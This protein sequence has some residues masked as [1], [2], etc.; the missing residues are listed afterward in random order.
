MKARWLTCSLVCA[1]VLGSLRASERQLVLEAM[2]QRPDDFWPRG[3]GHVVLAVPGSREEEK[4]YHE[5]GGSF[6]PAFA[7]FGISL[8]VLDAQGRMVATS[9]SLA[10]EQ[11]AQRLVWPREHEPPGVQ[12]ETPYYLATW[13]GRGLGKWQLD[14][15]LKAPWLIMPVVRSVGPA[16]APLQA[17]DWD[18][19]RLLVNDRWTVTLSAKVGNV[20]LGPEGPLTGARTNATGLRWGSDN[21]WA[22]ARLPLAGSQV[23]RILVQDQLA[24]TPPAL[25]CAQVRSGLELRLP[26]PEFEACLEAQVAHLLMG[27]VNN[28]TRPGEPNNY[29][30]NWL[31]DGAYVIVALARAGRLETAKDLCQP[32]A[33]DDFFGGFGA[34]ADGPGLALWALGEV[35]ALAH[36]SKFDQWAWP[37]I[38][39]KAQ[40]IEELLAATGPVRKAYAG[41][42]VPAHRKKPALD[43]VCDAAKDGLITGRM[44]WHRPVLFVNAVSYRGL[45]EAARAAERL[46][47]GAEAQR[48]RA[49]AARLREA[50]NQ[51]LKRPD[52][53]NERNYIC[54]LYPAW[55]VSDTNAF[56]QKLETFWNGSHDGQGRLKGVPLWTYF[57]VA[58]AHQWLALGKAERVWNDLRWFWTHQASPGLFTWWEGNGEENNFGRWESLARGWVKPLHV[59]P[60]Y[61]TAAEV[62]L[63]QLEMLA[64]VDDSGEPPSLVIG[65]GLPAA[66]LDRPLS[67]RGVGTRLG[68]VDWQWQAGKMTV[69]VHGPKC[70]VRLGAAFAANTPL[71]VK[72]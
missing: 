60:H 61:W 22:F 10:L 63:L 47:H 55:V 11:V 14:L 67:A 30:L 12:T 15:R 24:A 68:L 25:K 19:K 6:S 42:I 65:A 39:R 64:Y 33:Q 9:D 46:E 32:F 36:E 17:L 26:E 40:F 38:A 59:T 21:G 7:T 51:G 13:S 37:H 29:P 53:E 23:W 70:A 54:G 43:L 44:D 52:L 71:E 3:Q 45:L 34:E 35:S 57:S 66:W 18:G 1:V 49:A 2:K 31:R 41:P 56:R 58:T 69:R 72:F 48:W 27:L 16:G 4:A 8:W 28:E 5:P 50:W 62:L 20:E